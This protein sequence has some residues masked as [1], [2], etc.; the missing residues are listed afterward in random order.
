[1]FRRLLRRVRAHRTAA[2]PGLAADER[3]RLEADILHA[4][5]A[6]AGTTA[7]AY[8]LP[9]EDAAPTLSRRL[10]WGGAPPGTSRRGGRSRRER[11]WPSWR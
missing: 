9:D 11:S 10:A 7:E 2:T 4:I 8:P 3:E 6:A 1:M 5:L